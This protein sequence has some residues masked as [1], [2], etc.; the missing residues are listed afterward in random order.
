MVDASDDDVADTLTELHGLT[1]F[2]TAAMPGD[3]GVWW[4]AYQ[5]DQAVVFAGL[6]L[7]T[8]ARNSA[9]SPE[10]RLAAALEQGLQLRLMRGAEAHGRRVGWRGIFSDTTDNLV[11]ANNFIKAGYRLFEPEV[12]W[13]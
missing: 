7:S 11:S 1:F 4:F 5:G 3:L 9:T 8:Y 6:V 13:A 12:T 2:D 10:R